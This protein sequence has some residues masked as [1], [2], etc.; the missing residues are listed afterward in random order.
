MVRDHPDSSRQLPFRLSHSTKS[1]APSS[2]ERIRYLTNRWR[3]EVEKIP[4]VRF[5]PP[6]TTQR[7][8]VF[9]VKNVD[10][11][12]CRKLSGNATRSRPKHDRRR[13]HP[14]L[15]GIRVTPN[16]YTTPAELSRFVAALK[17]NIGIL[18][19]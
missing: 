13:P 12:N 3:K 19:T 10:S 9:D 5:T 7:P 1:W 8:R 16:V 18:M 6:L 2:E 11:T 17:R 4:G 15:N 14:D